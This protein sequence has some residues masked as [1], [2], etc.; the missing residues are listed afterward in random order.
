MYRQ[1]PIP[2]YD[3]ILLH[4]MAW[5]QFIHSS[6]HGHLSCFHLLV[7]VTSVPFNSFSPSA[8]YVLTQ[9]QLPLQSFSQVFLG[10]PGDISHDWCSVP[11]SWLQPLLPMPSMGGQLCQTQLAP[12]SLS[13]PDWVESQHSM[14]WVSPNS[15]VL[16]LMSELVPRSSKTRV[17]L[18]GN[19]QRLSLFSST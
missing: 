3:W 8:A 19:G 1:Y 17:Y 6:V 16:N 4:Y 18:F 10:I 14:C 2:F 15:P 9:W 13:F 11:G 7:T 12:L 5:P